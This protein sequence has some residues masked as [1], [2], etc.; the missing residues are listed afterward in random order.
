M[1]IRM[2]DICCGDSYVLN[3]V[4]KHLDN[5]LGVDINIKYL[6]KSREIWDPNFAT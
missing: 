3:Y 1:K 2:L 6:K 5:Y 4:G